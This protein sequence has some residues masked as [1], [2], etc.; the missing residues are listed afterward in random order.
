M[1]PVTMAGA[2]AL[3]LAE[4]LRAI[5]LFQWGSRDAPASLARSPQMWIENWRACLWNA[6][7]YA[8][9]SND[10][11]NGAVYGLP[12]RASGSC[13][14]N[15]PDG[16]A[17]WETSNA[18]WS[19]V[20]LAHCR[21]SRGGLARGR[22]HCKPAKFVMVRSVADDQSISIRLSRRQIATALR[23]TQWLRL[24]PTATISAVSILRSGMKRPFINRLCQ[25]G[26]TLRPLIWRAM[27]GQLI[28]RTGCGKRL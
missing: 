7:I 11:P 1:A 8:G 2:V 19:A 25:I 6:G 15:V 9:H 13:A 24:A 21:L 17:M 12:M 27:S 10:R 22:S 18:L 20:S 23:L 26:R 5:A 4:A 16:Q 28:G 14:A 3:S